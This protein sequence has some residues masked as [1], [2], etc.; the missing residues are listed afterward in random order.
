V[1]V[2]EDQEERRTGLLDCAPSHRLDDRHQGVAHGQADGPGRALLALVVLALLAQKPHE[3]G[4]VGPQSARLTAELAE[5]PRHP[6]FVVGHPD[7]GVEGRAQQGGD[8]PVGQLEEP[9]GLRHQH[10]WPVAQA[11]LDPLDEGA[12][13]GGLAQPVGRLDAHHLV[14]GVGV[15]RERPQAPPELPDLLGAPH[16]PAGPQELDPRRGRLHRHLGG[17]RRP[18]V[19]GAGPHGH[20]ARRHRH[21]HPHEPLLVAIGQR[22]ERLAQRRAQ[23]PQ[24]VDELLEIPHPPQGADGHQVFEPKEQPHHRRQVQPPGAQGAQFSL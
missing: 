17:D 11:L 10:H 9:R 16:G 1:G 22:A 5:P 3:P 21:R 14:D 2:L 23:G 8:R 12:N 4:Q 18:R 15:G 6:R 20:G 7:G 13:E 24:V 19:L